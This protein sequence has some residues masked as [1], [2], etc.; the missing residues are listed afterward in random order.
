MIMYDWQQGVPWMDLIRKN[1]PWLDMEI[2]GWILSLP[3]T[4]YSLG[5]P[6]HITYPSD[7]QTTP[8]ITP[9]EMV[10]KRELCKM[11]LKGEWILWQGHGE[12]GPERRAPQDGHAGILWVVVENIAQIC[13]HMVSVPHILL[14]S[15]PAVFFW[16]CSDKRSTWVPCSLT[17]PLSSDKNTDAV[18]SFLS[19]HKGLVSSQGW[20]S[21][22]MLTSFV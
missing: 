17:C 13:P 1:K 10:D 18:Q 14:L 12:M 15:S 4:T 11:L 6:S 19:F 2:W 20:Q 5:D 9:K 21:L 16:N 8:H 3:F 7:I 22:Q